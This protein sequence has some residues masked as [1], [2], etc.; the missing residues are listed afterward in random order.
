MSELARLSNDEEFNK[1]A[2]TSYKIL[3]I[4]MF[5]HSVMVHFEIRN[6][7]ESSAGLLSHFQKKKIIL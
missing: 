2:I 5:F 3:V 4:K 1:T 6:S 7:L